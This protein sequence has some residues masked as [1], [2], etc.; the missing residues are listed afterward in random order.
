MYIYHLYCISIFQQDFSKVETPQSSIPAGD[1][2]RRVEEPRSPVE[3][4]RSRARKM[5]IQLLK[6]LIQWDVNG[7]Y[8]GEDRQKDD[9]KPRFPLEN[10]LQNGGCSTSFCMLEGVLHGFTGDSILL[11]RSLSE[12][13]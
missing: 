12:I 3:I 4:N 13:V 5:V 11:F 6:M 2:R 9:V 8:P 7:T 1:L 10:D